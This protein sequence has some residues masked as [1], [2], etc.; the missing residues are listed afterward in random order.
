MVISNKHQAVWGLLRERAFMTSAVSL[1]LL[2]AL[3]AADYSGAFGNSHAFLRM[4]LYLVA[5]L[6]VG[7]PVVANAVKEVVARD[8]FNE[9]LLMTLAAL[10]AFYLGEYPEAVGIMLFYSVGELFQ[11]RAERKVRND[12]RA[13]VDLRPVRVMVVKKE[14][15][16]MCKPENVM[17]GDVIEVP[18]GGRVA[19]DGVLLNNSALFDTSALTGESMPRI[20]EEGECVSAGM[21]STDRSVCVRVEKEYK[22][23]ALSKILSMVQEASSHK[24]GTELFIRRFARIYTPVVM[25]LSVLVVAVPALLSGFNEAFDIYLGRALVFLVVACPCALVI[26]IPLGYF[27]GIGI[28]SA[29]GILFKGGNCLDAV[30]NL[31]AVLFDK[32]GTLTNGHFLVERVCVKGELADG[33]FLSLMAGVESH[34]THPLAK[35]IVAK[36]VKDGLQLKKV[37]SVEEVRG[38]G[39]KAKVDG[40]M[41]LA[42]HARFMASNGVQGDF[43]GEESTGTVVYGA[44]DGRLQGSLLLDDRPKEDA[45][46]AIT[47]LKELGIKKVG[48]L[49]GDKT[50]IVARLARQLGVDEYRGDLLPEEKM[51]CLR[52]MLE[53]GRV[54]FVGDG[55]ND[56]PVLALS[57]VGF[58]MGSAGSDAAVETADVVIQSDRPS[59]VAEAVKIGRITHRVVWCNIVFAIG[60]KVLI[61]L[62]GFLGIA[63]LWSAVLSD[64]G[65]ALLCAMNVFVIQ[66]LCRPRGK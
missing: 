22:D 44:V 23:S 54:A 52:M 12:I 18:A 61:M 14:G 40:R 42:G 26:S 32:T 1:L 13:L 65:V 30:R 47:S 6:P 17:P 64:T 56:A 25:A 46:L 5:F 2:L 59:K 57:T 21:I 45:S 58:A 16:I 49:S 4:A 27:S 34:S 10:G 63:G 41:V 48:V 19:L 11:D 31:Y 35:A 24:A 20:V 36:A 43:A 38:M 33:E 55:I 60:V 29:R 62:L 37:D 7:M 8:V 3:T 28:A 9:Y 51:D 15:R 66:Y 39:M 53:K 50:E